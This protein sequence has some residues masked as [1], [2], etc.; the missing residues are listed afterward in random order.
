[1]KDRGREIQIAEEEDLLPNF[2]L[3]T[4]DDFNEFEESLNTSLQVQNL[5]VS[6]SLSYTF[7]Y[8]L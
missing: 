6:N 1:M 3:K 4:I 5:Y 7:V 8:K 2:P